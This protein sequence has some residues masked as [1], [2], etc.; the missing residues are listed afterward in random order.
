LFWSNYI[1]IVRFSVYYFNI[2]HRLNSMPSQQTK[3]DA[4][5]II[6]KDKP[7]I[8]RQYK[9]H[10]NDFKYIKSCFQALPFQ[11]VL[12]R[13]RYKVR[14]SSLKRILSLAQYVALVFAK[15]TKKN[16]VRL[17]GW[18][19]LSNNP[20]RRS[21]IE[22]GFIVH[23]DYWGRGIGTYLANHLIGHIDLLPRI[24]YTYCLAYVQG[25][26]PRARKIMDKIAKFHEG[27]RILDTSKQCIK[28]VVPLKKIYL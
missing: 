20:T 17:I 28:Y 11:V 19:E 9:S 27:S 14:I 10:T 1:H 16:F 23:P 24:R 4:R 5:E 26:N 22:I 7:Y 13:Y 21:I 18:G 2:I 25:Y 6:I 8:I 12:Q 15:T 3:V